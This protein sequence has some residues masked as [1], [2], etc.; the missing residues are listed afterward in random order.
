MWT[1]EGGGTLKNIIRPIVSDMEN[2]KELKSNS[3]DLSLCIHAI[4][5]TKNP[6]RAFKEMIRVTKPGGY[7]LLAF[8]NRES[9]WARLAWFGYGNIT[10]VN[11]NDFVKNEN[12]KKIDIIE[13]HTFYM[14]HILNRLLSHLFLGLPIIVPIII[15]TK[16]PA[17]VSRIKSIFARKPTN[18]YLL[19]KKD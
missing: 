11:T 5:V 4:Y 3:V 1:D 17:F 16:E 15:P 14:F 13:V 8:I 18:I 2:I 6:D 7:I 19:L 9:F 12:V 10:W